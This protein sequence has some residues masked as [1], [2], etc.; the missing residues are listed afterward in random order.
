MIELFDAKFT[1]V[2]GIPNIPILLGAQCGR[3]RGT[4]RTIRFKPNNFVR[5]RTK[6]KNP[7]TNV[8]TVSEYATAAIVHGTP[9][10]VYVKKTGQS[11]RDHTWEGSRVSTRYAPGARMAETPA[12]RLSGSS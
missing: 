1:V 12:W 3:M 6:M 7:T 2:S 10:T 5:F 9:A 11:T 4:T 8:Y